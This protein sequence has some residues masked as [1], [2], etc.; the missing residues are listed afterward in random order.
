MLLLSA[1]GVRLAA[2]ADVVVVIISLLFVVFVVH[3]VGR[4]VAIPKV[5]RYVARGLAAYFIVLCAHHEMRISLNNSDLLAYNILFSSLFYKYCRII[6]YYVIYTN[7][8]GFVELMLFRSR[9]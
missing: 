6:L 1:V 4:Y 8:F 9:I 5:G 3:R 2:V 7:P